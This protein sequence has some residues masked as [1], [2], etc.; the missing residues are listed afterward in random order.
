[1]GREITDKTEP[2]WL[3]IELQAGERE[4]QPFPSPC[5]PP[6]FAV[7]LGMHRASGALLSVSHGQACLSEGPLLTVWRLRKHEKR[8]QGRAGRA[9]RSGLLISPEPFRN[10]PL[11]RFPKESC[12]EDEE[13]EARV[14][15][16]REGDGAHENNVSEKHLWSGRTGDP[17]A[18]GTHRA[19]KLKAGF[20]KTRCNNADFRDKFWE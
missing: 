14:R 8:L 3:S 2:L 12:D 6:H 7:F 1:M 13:E 15:Q 16:K 20:A 18:G 10:L 9:A 19:E 11:F 4:K 17:A 5:L